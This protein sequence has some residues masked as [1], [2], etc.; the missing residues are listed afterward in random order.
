[1]IT[2]VAAWRMPGPKF[3]LDGS[4]RIGLLHRI[5]VLLPAKS[6]VLDFSSET[7]TVAYKLAG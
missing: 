6:N 7:Y 1:M 5:S 3:T 2:E 4:A